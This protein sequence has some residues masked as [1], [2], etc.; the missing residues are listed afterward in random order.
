MVTL[1]SI[2]A[3]IIHLFVD[4]GSLALALVAWCGAI[5]LA[6]M[7]LPESHAAPGVA[8]FLGCDLILLGNVLG[9]ARTRARVA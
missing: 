8:L 6:T 3:E 2:L 5:G 7:V 4:D 1:K 9:A